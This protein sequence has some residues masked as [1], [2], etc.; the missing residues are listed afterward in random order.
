MSDMA[1]RVLVTGASRGIGRSIALAIAA[2]GFHVTVHYRGN[3]EKAEE[4]LAAI[5]ESGGAGDL[6]AFDIGDRAGVRNALETQIEAGGAY[7]G[8]V[9]NAGINSDAPLPGLT[10]E[11]WD[12]VIHTNLDGFYNVL[13]T[14]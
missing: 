8:A 12:S 6:V 2:E 5:R 7:W 11:D 4:T 1:R 10:D 9:L 3:K 13:I 14:I